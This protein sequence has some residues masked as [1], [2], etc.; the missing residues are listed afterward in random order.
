M[1]KRLAAILIAV[2]AGLGPVITSPAAAADDPA[3]KIKSLTTDCA[4]DDSLACGVLAG[5]YEKGEGTKKDL[6]AALKLYLRA[7]T[8]GDG[9]YCGQ[10]GDAHMEGSGTAKNPARAIALY[11]Q[12]CDLDGDNACSALSDAYK[13]G[14]GVTKDALLALELD[15]KACRL[16]S[17]MCEMME[18]MGRDLLMD[19]NKPLPPIALNTKSC[20]S[21]DK[22]WCT[23]LGIRFQDGEG[24]ESNE[25]A[26]ARFY[27][28]ACD[29]G[30]YDACANL[31]NVMA[32]FGRYD[33]P[34]KPRNPQHDVL[35][36]KA[37]Q[38]ACELEWGTSCSLLGDMVR[39]GIGTARNVVLADQLR[40]RGCRLDSLICPKEMQAAAKAR[41]GKAEAAAPAPASASSPTQPKVAATA[42]AAQAL[43]Q[44]GSAPAITARTPVTPGSL[45]ARGINLHRQMDFQPALALLL[46]AAKAQPNDPRVHAYLADTYGWLGMR[47][48]SQMAADTAMRLDPEAMSILR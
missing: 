13:E 20:L 26:A 11:R 34:R 16:G 48:E 1:V 40:E 46:E 5:Y 42:P 30:S 29:A 8:L 45:L 14:R 19:V 17:G 35:A 28:L 21:G 6:A 33:Y 41:A 3:A 2:L 18:R 4:K 12:G 15:E 36:V 25:Q 44:Q 37:Y 23:V 43:R 7:C 10:A 24:V 32:R 22:G 31:G 9:F 27:T 47:S 38:R 39:R